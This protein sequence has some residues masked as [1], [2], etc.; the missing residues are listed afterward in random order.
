MIFSITAFI[1]WGHFQ[2]FCIKDGANVEPNMCDAEIMP[3]SDEPCE[4]P[5]PTVEAPAEGSGDGNATEPDVDGD[6]KPPEEGRC[7]QFHIEMCLVF[8]LCVLLFAMKLSN[9]HKKKCIYSKTGECKE[10]YEDPWIFG[11]EDDTNAD[12]SEE[13]PPQDEQESGS[14]DGSGDE[15]SK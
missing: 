12:E 14:G 5:C 15:V 1:L 8:N 4:A 13:T 9:K 7:I 11:G 6:M 3:L 10:Y 2:V